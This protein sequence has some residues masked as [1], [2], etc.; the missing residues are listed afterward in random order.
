M[1]SARFG[2]IIGLTTGLVLGLAL[3]GTGLAGQQTPS[4]G[5]AEP[6]VLQFAEGQT[7]LSRRARSE[8]RR[9][10][11]KALPS[12]E[13]IFVVGY[14]DTS[15]SKSRNYILS[16]ERARAVRR[17]IID[18]LGVHPD[19][20]LAVGRG[21][22][23]PLADNGRSKGRAENRRVEIRL[24]RMV[25]SSWENL[26]TP[27][28]AK[29]AA[30]IEALVHHAKEALR[31]KRLP[32]AFQFLRL[33][34]NRGGAQIGIWQCVYGISEYYAQAPFNEIKDHLTAALRMNPFDRDARDYLG[35]A[36]ARDKVGRD[37]VTADMGRSEHDAIAVDSDEQAYE[38]LRLFQVQPLS[39]VQSP[40]T[41]LMVWACRD[42]QGRPVRYYFDRSDVMAWAFTDDQVT[43]AADI[44]PEA[45]PG[46]SVRA[47]NADPSPPADKKRFTAQRLWNSRVFR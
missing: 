17:V 13:K 10:P 6:V 2:R 27:V 46:R 12:G 23:N 24:V 15:G 43:A 44:A 14:A 28:N 8:I 47:E 5:K 30:A 41:A 21:S 1:R 37:Q 29:E 31:R 35:R 36:E 18:T 4:G 33:A 38:Y 34:R 25:D 26:P 45:S 39:R 42:A 19:Q 32:D 16:Y 20:V 11:V 9:L 3:A 7:V 22:E 40:S